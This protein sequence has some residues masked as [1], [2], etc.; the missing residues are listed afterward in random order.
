MYDVENPAGFGVRLLALILDGLLVSLPL[1]LLCYILFGSG[2][3][4]SDFLMVLYGIILPIVWY[5]YTVGKRLMGIRIARVDGYEVGIGTMLLRVIVAGLIYGITFGI[6]VII[7]ALMV[8]FREDNRA[9][10]DFIAGTYVT[11]NEPEVY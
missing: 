11:Y 9:I 7:S 1:A 2:E 4:F 6:G 10:H 5:G 8:G 3:R